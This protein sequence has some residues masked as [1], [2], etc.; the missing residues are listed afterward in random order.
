MNQPDT[1]QF[2]NLIEANKGILYSVCNNYCK[3]PSKRDDLAQEILIQ[4][5][6]SMGNWDAKFPFS[7]WMYRVALNVAISYYRK[8]KNQL[9]PVSLDEQDIQ[10]A[11]DNDNWTEKEEKLH[12]LQLLISQL[13]S[14]DKA[15]MLLYLDGKSYQE[16]GMI[17]GIT[18]TNVATK[19]SRIK[20][21]LKQSFSK[22][23]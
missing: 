12:Q 2:T 5:W 10:V 8:E 9:A 7:T 16:I 19:I 11:G 6:K 22:I 14:L 13:K 15:L 21:H 3:D 20:E 4:L 17:L 1:I 23:A 18:Q